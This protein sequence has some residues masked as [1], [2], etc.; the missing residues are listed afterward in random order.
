MLDII[1]SAGKRYAKVSCGLLYVETE[2]NIIQMYNFIYVFQEVIMAY[3][4]DAIHHVGIPVK[5][6]NIDKVKD[7]YERLLGF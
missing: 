1:P 2:E 7:F 4:L 6:E 3:T 5:D